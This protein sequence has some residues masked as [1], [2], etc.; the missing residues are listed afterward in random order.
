[1]PDTQTWFPWAMQIGAGALSGIAVGFALRKLAA[2]VLL[3]VG[4]GI[5]LLY[6]LTQIDVAVVN[7]QALDAQFKTNAEA[8]WRWIEGMLD[9]L[10]A[11]GVGFAGGVLVG[12]RLR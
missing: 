10:T 6:G 8:A 2:L 9:N 1:M 3:V 7:W 4:L 5:L 12:W 11:V